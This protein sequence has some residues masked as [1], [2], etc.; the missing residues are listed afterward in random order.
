MI[1]TVT[2]R[3]RSI[4]VQFYPSS[5]TSCTA[6]ALFAALAL[7]I[8]CVRD[9]V[10]ISDVELLE[11]LRA[12]DPPLVLDVRS[13][14]EFE[15]G[16]IAGARNLPYDEVGERL[17]ELGD[18]RDREVVVYCERGFRAAK[19]AD[20]LEGAGFRVVH[21]EGDMSGWRSK[22]LPCTGC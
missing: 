7:G 17:A 6:L 2:L 11:R 22:K 14:K 13:P 12:A 4:L 20:V 18:S 19:A 21:L 1:C 5:R 10:S 9:M 15:S 16:H 8:G 3:L